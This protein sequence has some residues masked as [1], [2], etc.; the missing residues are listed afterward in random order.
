MPAE[1]RTT[2][3]KSSPFVDAESPLK[4]LIYHNHTPLYKTGSMF[5][6]SELT[7]NQICQQEMTW[8]DSLRWD[9]VELRQSDA[10]M[11]R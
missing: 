1:K 10:Y 8:M 7:L 4:L 3:E 11:R 9:I 5:S 6:W 2:T